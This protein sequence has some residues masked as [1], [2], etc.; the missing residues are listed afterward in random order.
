MPLTIETGSGTHA[1][2]VEEAVTRAEREYGLMNRKSMPPDQG[3]IFR[4]DSEQP[5]DMWMKDTLIPLDMVFIRGDG[6]VAGIRADAVPLSEEIIPSPGP[7]RF[8]LELNGGTAAR[9]GA[10]PG[11]RVRTRLIRQPAGK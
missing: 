10:K 6:T 9:I 5:V 7:V 4:F 1:F 2:E 3:M 11:D 8:V